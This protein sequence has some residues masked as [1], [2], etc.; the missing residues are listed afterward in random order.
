MRPFLVSVLLA[1]L[2]CSGPVA[3]E[4]TAVTIRRDM[5]TNAIARL[6]DSSGVIDN[7]LKFRIAA[8]LSGLDRKLRPGR[9]LLAMN[10]DELAVL[11]V[12]TQAGPTTA[13][14][15]VPE[16]FR[17]SQVAGLLEQNCVC[18]AQDFTAACHDSILLRSL[19]VPA[20]S[21]EGYLFPDTYCFETGSEPSAVLEK[22]VGRFFEVYQ[23]LR[24]GSNP[25]LN[26]HKTVILAS[27][28]EREA[29]LP[30]E[31]TT[32]A[33]V[34]LNRLRRKLPLQSCATVEYALPK[35]KSKLT[36]ADTRVDSPYN[37]YI[38]L[39]LPP[40]PICSPGA[41]ALAAALNPA[42]TEFLYFVARGDG[43]HVFSRTWREHEDIG[44]RLRSGR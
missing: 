27:V 38:H 22:M 6:L 33:G 29:V 44:R 39:G 3:T 24:A 14:V 2:A 8:R 1:V 10:M 15:T 41:R 28:L 21:A 11:R 35:H 40:G 20:A 12:L 30:S 19:A 43:G 26:D 5:S 34:F 18:A 17:L 37:T 4:K 9:Y 23:R 32:I 42:R 13:R 16:G 31:L 25:P 36:Y 7:Q